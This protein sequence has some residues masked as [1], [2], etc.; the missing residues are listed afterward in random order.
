M[1]RS[2]FHDL[3]DNLQR[4]V[5]YLRISVTDR[6]NLRCR[7]CA[8]S[9]PA[10]VAKE[11]LLT[12]EE[13]Y[14]IVRIGVGL[15]ITKVRL[16]GGE[17]L[18]RHGIVNFLDQL[19]RIPALAD[20]SLTTNGTLVDRLGG[21]LKQAGL[22]RINISLDTMD[23]DRFKRMTGLDL[24]PT[25]WKGIM[26][27]VELGFA[28]LKINTVVM[29]G[30]NDDEIERMAALSL[31]YPL[32]VR[33]IEYMPIGT[34]PVAA[35]RYFIPMAQIQ[36]RLNRLGTLVPVPHGRHDGPARRYRFKGAPGEIGLIGSMSSPF[37]STC[38]RIRLTATGHL[39][40][41][42]LA[43]DQVDVITPLR[44][45]ATDRQLVALMVQTLAL[46]KGE[47]QLSFARNKGLRTKMVS[48]GG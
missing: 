35:H 10:R 23:R 24:F 4:A 27:A 33:F 2:T 14:R 13:L 22:H 8:P 11:H 42:L 46:K 47:H 17:P 21:R 15:G 38:N 3:K 7:Y 28:P 5:T 16:T 1:N 48:I 20:I 26:A 29:K 9:R 41:C 25:V 19:G 37:C 32:H 31:R 44:Q 34:D 36:D 40:P 45:G 43:D 39:R 12:L 30:F 6:C 18:L